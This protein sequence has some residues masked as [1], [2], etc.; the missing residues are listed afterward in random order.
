MAFAQAVNRRIG[1]LREILA[2]EMMQAAIFSGQDSQG[3][4]IAHRAD[5][6]LASAGHRGKDQF[7]IFHRPARHQLAAAAHLVRGLILLVRA[8]AFQQGIHRF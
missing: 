8:R 4:I 5:R 2:E 3:R 1:D 6:L 7:H